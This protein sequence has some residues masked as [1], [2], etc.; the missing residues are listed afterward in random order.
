M[1]L[2]IPTDC[3]ARR[4]SRTSLFVMAALYSDAGSWPVKVR[5]LSSAGALIEG[6]TIPPPGTNIRL[7][8]GS[9]SILGQIVWSRSERA[10]V[11]F[12]TSVSVNEWLPGNRASRPQQRV[13]DLVQQIKSSSVET[14]V[15][16]QNMKSAEVSAAELTRLRIA[17]ES[18][19]EDLSADPDVV[20]RHMAKLQT[21]DLTA[22]MLRK[23]ADWR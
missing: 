13:D 16:P 19:A 8:R 14:P 3:D 4:E 15:H 23:L 1:E 12:E 7:C 11:R 21:L 2:T 20:R 18:L 17:V 6:G 22:Q 9:Q 5:D 10:G